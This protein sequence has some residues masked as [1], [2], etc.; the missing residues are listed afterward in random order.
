MRYLFVVLP[1][2]AFVP[3]LGLKFCET[4]TLKKILLF[5]IYLIFVKN[6]Y[7]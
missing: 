1:I 7:Y 4:K 3:K 2:T 6:A 5:K